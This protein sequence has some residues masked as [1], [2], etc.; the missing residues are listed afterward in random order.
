MTRD[1]EYFT[2][3]VVNASISIEDIGNCAI[4]ANNDLGSFWFLI[5]QTE[6]GFS[7]IFEYGPFIFNVEELPKSC[8]WFYKRISYSENALSKIIDKFLNDGYR[9]ITQAE[10]ISMEEAKEN[11]RN[12]A[13][14]IK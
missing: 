7:E 3:V 10:E 14:Y 12:L 6:L 8:N 11:C 5:I 4:R 1:F 13:D 9:C 2:K